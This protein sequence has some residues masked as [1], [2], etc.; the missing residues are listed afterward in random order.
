M[1]MILDYA[2]AQGFLNRCMKVSLL[3]SDMSQ[4]KPLNV[5]Y[6]K[7]FM[8]LDT[9]GLRPPVRSCVSIPSDEV[10]ASFMVKHED[11]GD[12]KDKMTMS[13]EGLVENHHV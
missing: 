12:F 6:V 1:I 10:I 2:K 5:E 13:S 4:F 3:V 8:E 7:Y 9:N 11:T